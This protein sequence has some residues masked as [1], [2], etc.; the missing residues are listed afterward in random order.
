MATWPRPSLQARQSSGADL[1]RRLGSCQILRRRP[2]V[3]DPQPALGQSFLARIG[4]IVRYSFR[5]QAS[6]FGLGAMRLGGVSI[7]R[8]GFCHRCENRTRPD[9]HHVS[10]ARNVVWS[11]RGSGKI[12][13]HMARHAPTEICNYSRPLG[14]KAP[15]RRIAM[16]PSNETALHQRCKT[17]RVLCLCQ[18]RQ[19]RTAPA[20]FDA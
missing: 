16:K 4:A 11:G 1:R 19:I 13:N 6:D 15:R 18:T 20:D 5:L 7:R 14:R 2:A 17:A 3:H 12:S 8:T 10:L 9:V